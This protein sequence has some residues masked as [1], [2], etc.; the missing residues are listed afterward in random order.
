MGV[1]DE[2][3]LKSKERWSAQIEDFNAVRMSP[4]SLELDKNWWRYVAAKLACHTK[5]GE[6]G[7]LGLLAHSGPVWNANSM[8]NI[9]NPIE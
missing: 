5:S 8:W 6:C 1:M 2:K 4:R 3:S 9:G 7:D